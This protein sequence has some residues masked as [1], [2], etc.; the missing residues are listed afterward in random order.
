[1]VRVRA[2]GPF[3]CDLN[4]HSDV[5]R[6]SSS[7][8]HLITT[9]ISLIVSWSLIVAIV[10][11]CHVMWYIYFYKLLRV[12]CII[13][14]IIINNLYSGDVLTSVADRCHNYVHVVHSH[15]PHTYYSFLLLLPH[16]RK[17]KSPWPPPAI[18]CLD[19][20]VF[21]S[22]IIVAPGRPFSF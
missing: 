22:L 7:R 2:W 5:G 8:V 12:F 21:T 15:T 17:K 20:S 4:C 13:M 16:S 6:A 14:I 18:L 3:G 11:L 1:M 9:Y 19:P 10:L